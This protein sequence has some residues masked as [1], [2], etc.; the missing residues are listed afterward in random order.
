MAVGDLSNAVLS[1]L[2]D[3]QCHTVD[4]LDYALAD[5]QRREIVKC[6]GRLIMRG[7]LERVE[8]GCYQ[9]TEDGKR[10]VASG[11]AISSGP[12][13]PDRGHCRKPRNT[14][15]QRAWTA[16]RMSGTFTVGDIAMAAASGS[17]VSP[18]Q[19]LQKY[20]WALKRAGYLAELPIRAKGTALT[21]NGFKRFRLMRDTGP[22]APVFRANKDCL[23]DHNLGDRG[24][25]VSCQ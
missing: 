1:R 14:M 7:L 18:E 3:G 21:S 20:F 19:N 8:I 15:R 12:Y 13:R 22:T 6:A 16:M 17:E 9:L 4:H 25:E 23:F 2:S 24:E 10:I 5:F 11:E